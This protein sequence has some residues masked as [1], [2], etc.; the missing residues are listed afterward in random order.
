MIFQTFQEFQLRYVQDYIRHNNN[1][2]GGVLNR[3]RIQ[4]V[5]RICDMSDYWISILTNKY[6]VKTRMSVKKNNVKRHT[7]D[8]HT[9]T[10]IFMDIEILSEV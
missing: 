3:S 5:R 7:L 9:F 10:D 2:I 4:K 8:F 6:F 1:T